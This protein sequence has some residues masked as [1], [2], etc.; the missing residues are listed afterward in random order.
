MTA[1]VA[2][3]NSLHPLPVPGIPAGHA[4]LASFSPGPEQ[5]ALL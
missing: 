3:T 2:E 1:T 4:A 5:A